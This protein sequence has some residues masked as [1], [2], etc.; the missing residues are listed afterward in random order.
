MKFHPIL[1]MGIWIPVLRW[2]L[3]F[4]DVGQLFCVNL[5]PFGV[6]VCFCSDFSFK[7]VNAMHCA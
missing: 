7:G 6:C 4:E 2:V 1:E 3:I 5:T